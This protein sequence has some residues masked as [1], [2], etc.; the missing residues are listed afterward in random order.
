MQHRQVASHTC[1]FEQ[2]RGQHLYVA[3]L[4]LLKIFRNLLFVGVA[5]LDDPWQYEIVKSRH[6]SGG[7]GMLLRKKFVCWLDLCANLVWL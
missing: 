2:R 3:L 5:T 7:S 1:I 6:F 4:N